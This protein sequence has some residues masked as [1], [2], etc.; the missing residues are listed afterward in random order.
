M[1]T[2]RFKR[3]LVGLTSSPFSLG[4][5]IQQHLQA[6]EQH[7]PES[8]ALIRKSLYKSSLVSFGVKERGRGKE[9]GL[10]SS[11]PHCTLHIMRATRGNL[12]PLKRLTFFRLPSQRPTYNIVK[13]CYTLLSLLCTELNP[14][15][16]VM[17]WISLEAAWPSG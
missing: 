3:A 8:V 6:R 4:G 11:Q 14:A 9:W 15:K 13:S 5:V 16:K 1:E 10:K 2:F 17:E 12:S 7:K